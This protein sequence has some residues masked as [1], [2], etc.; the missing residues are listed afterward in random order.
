MREQTLIA[1]MVHCESHEDQIYDGIFRDGILPVAHLFP[2]ASSPSASIATMLQAALQ[3]MRAQLKYP[4]GEITTLARPPLHGTN[5]ALRERSEEQNELAVPN[6]IQSP[7]DGGY[8]WVC[9][10]TCFTVNCFT[11]GVVAVGPQLPY[12]I[13]G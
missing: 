13:E 10:A 8:G 5:V 4:K 2:S 12:I 1:Y 7:P 6:P 9:L 11:W 3:A